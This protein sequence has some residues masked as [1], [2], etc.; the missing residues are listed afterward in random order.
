MTH[1]AKVSLAFFAN[2]AHKQQR[3]FSD[4][5]AG[6]ECLIQSDKSNQPATIIGNPGR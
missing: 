4:D 2:C 1:A 5:L 3:S 6:V